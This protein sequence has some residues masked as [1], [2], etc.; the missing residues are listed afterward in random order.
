MQSVNYDRWLLA[1][2]CILH[3][4]TFWIAIN[5]QEII[6]K[7]LSTKREPSKYCVHIL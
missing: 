1:L 6:I 4:P 5:Q 7:V 3:L 2:S